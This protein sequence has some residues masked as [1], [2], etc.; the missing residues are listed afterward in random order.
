LEAFADLRAE[1]PK[2]FPSWERPPSRNLDVA[3]FVAAGERGRKSTRAGDGDGAEAAF[4]EQVAI[5]PL[6]PEPWVARAMLAAA[7]GDR[8]LALD[9]LR[10]AVLRGFT[11]LRSVERAE[12]WVRLRRH[13]EFLRLQDAVPLLLEYE[14]NWPGWDTSR[15]NVVPASVAVVLAD[16]ARV[17][18]LLDGMAPALGE[19]HV[20]LWRRLL[21]RASAARL[22]AYLA[23]RPAATDVADALGQLMALY[24]AD[25]GLGWEALE[26]KAATRLGRVADLALER[27]GAGAARAGALVCRAL[28]R[29]GARNRR[30]R[31]A[32]AAAADIRASLGE[33]L[34][35]HPDSPFAPL[36]VAGLV[37]TEIET[38]RDD[39]AA[40]AFAEFLGRNAED[41]AA[42]VAARKHLGALAL[43]AGG[44]PAFRVRT[45][46]GRAV[47][48]DA[49]RGRVAVI[50]F[51]A[52]WCGPC[53]EDIPTL[54]RIAARYGEEVVVV[55]VSL[56]ERDATSAE[57]LQRWIADRAVPGLQ[58]GD[59][60]GWESDVVRAF[61]VRE[62]PFSVV[63]DPG[64]RVLAVG[65][66]GKDL[67]RAVRAAV[68]DRAATGRSR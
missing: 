56:D 13:G 55:G 34:A 53:V 6:N 62:I 14:Q 20:R 36:A 12:A 33:V 41:S 30:G 47:D 32:T 27:S 39:A 50:D 25:A 1:Y 11:D 57:A 51:W 31:L 45:L 42:A 66:R 26:P 28:A 68:G 5:C 2:Y 38:G 48:R 60:A 61:G 9:H 21:D 7:R 4:A 15:A 54:Q 49:L 19:R 3:R 64:G 23:E 18:D 22:E 52:T 44:L 67:E 63:A 10:A 8:P 43:R 37:Q 17:A 16:R 29:N 58:V 24:T 40:A 65:R 46:D 35:A 59:G